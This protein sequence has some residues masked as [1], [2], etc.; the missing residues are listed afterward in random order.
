MQRASKYAQQI[1]HTQQ[2]VAVAVLIHSS[3][4]SPGGPTC[5]GLLGLPISRCLLSRDPALGCPSQDHHSGLTQWGDLA[6]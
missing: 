3:Q 6:R 1:I 2:M 4:P 5:A